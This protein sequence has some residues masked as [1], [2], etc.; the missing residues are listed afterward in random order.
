MFGVSTT[1]V[2]RAG[3]QAADLGRSALG[4]APRN[5]GLSPAS[6][7]VSHVPN[8][9]RAR[10]VCGGPRPHHTPIAPNHWVGLPV[11]ADV[12]RGCTTR[13]E[14][15]QSPARRESLFDRTGSRAAETP[16]ATPGRR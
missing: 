10:R 4:G 9:H 15:E 14:L 12:A 3:Q 11:D 7:L 2:A 13:G 1:H 8:P 6:R 5:L 16:T